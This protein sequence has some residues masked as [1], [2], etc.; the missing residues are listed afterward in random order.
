MIAFVL[1]NDSPLAGVCPAEDSNFRGTPNDKLF[2]RNAQA[3]F[4]AV[5]QDAVEFDCWV[6]EQLAPGRHEPPLGYPHLRCR[7]AQAL[8]LLKQREG[9]DHGSDIQRP[10]R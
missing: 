8:V 2:A 10:A 6:D 4:L 5:D 7:E 1:Q 3:S 9:L